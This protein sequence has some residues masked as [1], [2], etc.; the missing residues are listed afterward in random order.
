[1]HNTHLLEKISKSL[2]EVCTNHN[3]KKIKNL[4]LTVNANS[5]V[6]DET[7]YD[8]LQNH[9]PDVI[10]EWTQIKVEEGDL[11]DQTAILHSIEGETLEQ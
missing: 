1:M 8:H 11:P 3:I 5:H 6:N 10:G 7:L 2:Q 4:V 9:N